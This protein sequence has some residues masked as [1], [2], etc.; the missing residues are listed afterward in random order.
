M[1]I[2]NKD[3]YKIKHPAG[4]LDT[5]FVDTQ[6]MVNSWVQEGRD[7][8]SVLIDA[9]YNTKLAPYYLN[10]SLDALQNYSYTL[11]D[12]LI[13]C[14]FRNEECTADQFFH[15]YTNNLGNCY[16]VIDAMT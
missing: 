12:M 2:C 4:E 13:S 1:T 16:Q 11:N 8:L 6:E 5:V 10:Q 15:I 9:N 3:P 7:S 14:L